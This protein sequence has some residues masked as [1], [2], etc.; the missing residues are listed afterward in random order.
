MIGHLLF[1]NFSCHIHFKSARSIAKRPLGIAKLFEP[2]GGV[3]IGFGISVRLWLDLWLSPE[4]LN[5][6]GRA[7][8]HSKTSRIR[9]H[10]RD[11]ARFWSAAVLC[12]FAF[13]R[14]R[15]T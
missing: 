7:Q 5:E 15:S 8:P 4:P 11:A 13:L 3:K 14:F 9:Q 12:R 1:Q 6:S 2:C 10:A